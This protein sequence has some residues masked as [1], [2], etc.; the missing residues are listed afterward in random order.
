MIY[1]IYTIY[2]IF[3]AIYGAYGQPAATSVDPATS[4]G[5][6][7]P[8]VAVRVPA[9][10]AT[11]GPTSVSPQQAQQ[12]QQACGAW[13]QD[14][15]IVSNFLNLGQGQLVPNLFQQMAM[16]AFNAEVDELAHKAVLDGIIGND[17]T[18]SVANLTLSNGSFQSVVSN[19]QIM[20]MQGRVRVSLVNTINSI[21]CTQILP[22]I[23]K[24]S[25]IN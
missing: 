21:R 22:S 15:G 24:A 13:V 4:T 11:G 19:L 1:T 10:G 23:G 16:Q 9:S 2:T 3:L 20:S 17:P 18:V 6:F 5:V 7:G 14:T 12:L 8:F 25:S